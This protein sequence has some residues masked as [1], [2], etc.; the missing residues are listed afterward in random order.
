MNCLDNLNLPR[1]IPEVV[2]LSCIHGW[3]PSLVL[4]T[5]LSLQRQFHHPDH[6]I[7]YIHLSHYDSI[8]NGHVLSTFSG[9]RYPFDLHMNVT[10]PMAIHILVI[11]RV[12]RE[13]WNALGNPKKLSVDNIFFEASI[14]CQDS[15]LCD[16]RPK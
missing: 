11:Q 4:S 1:S 12:Q 14:F 10:C 13:A 5:S 2:W 7:Y 3:R 16:G 9:L 15:L 6:I 8:L